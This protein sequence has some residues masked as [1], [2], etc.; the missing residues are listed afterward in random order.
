MIKQVHSVFLALLM[1]TFV[2]SA[3]GGDKAAESTA[4]PEPSPSVSNETVSPTE[5]PTA[6]PLASSETSATPAATVVV[7]SSATPKPTQAATA[8]PKPAET[9]KPTPK[10]TATPK[11][12]ESGA[13]AEALFKQS[14]TSCHGVDLEGDIGPNLQK[15]GGHLTKA[16]ITAQIT[17]GGT[18][19]PPFGKRLKTEE[20]QTLA[21]W[22]AAK[23]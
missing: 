7:T 19:M 14:C 2:L 3:C 1:V 6:T 17:D 5:A 13:A 16:Q 15:A 22:L 12:E 20:I 4:S 23:K 9:A 18:A 10:P 11:A 21:I 8:S